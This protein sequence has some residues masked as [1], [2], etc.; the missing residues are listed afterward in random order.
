[1][2][3]QLFRVSLGNFN[4][5][6]GGTPVPSGKPPCWVALNRRVTQGSGANSVGAGF[7]LGPGLSDTPRAAL[8][9]AGGQK[10]LSQGWL[11]PQLQVGMM[12]K[13]HEHQ[14]TPRLPGLHQ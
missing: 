9:E 7:L 1:M 10:P 4:P 5:G 8:W 14:N 6:L 2:S 3:L 13:P 12:A 11:Q